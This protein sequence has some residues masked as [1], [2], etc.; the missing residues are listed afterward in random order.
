MQQELQAFVLALAD[1]P[2]ESNRRDSKNIVGLGWCNFGFISSKANEIVSL[3]IEEH[4]VTYLW[5]SLEDAYKDFCNKN[6]IK[7]LQFKLTN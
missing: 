7:I 6:W 2:I 3:V 1:E 5:N 4:D